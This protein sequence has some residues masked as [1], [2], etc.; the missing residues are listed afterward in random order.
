MKNMIG[1]GILLLGMAVAASAEDYNQWAAYKDITVNTTSAGAN[2]ANN[3]LGIPVLVRLTSSN[4][5]DFAVPGTKASIRFETTSKHLPYQVERWDSTGG[6]VAEVWV[7]LDTAKGNNSSPSIRMRWG[8]AG[9]VDSSNGGAVFAQSN[10]FV[11]AWHLGD[12]P[13]ITARP[14]AVTGA[15]PAT[16][17]NDAGTFGGGTYVTPTGVI[18]K[19]DVIR[20]AGTRNAPVANSDYLDIGSGATGSTQSPY[21]GNNTYAGYTDFSTGF[22]YSFW[23]NPGAAA[24]NFTYMLE[25]SNTNGGTNNIQFFRP[26]TATTYRYEHVNG[27][28]SA[29][30]KTTASGSLVQGSWQ[31]IVVTVGTGATPSV[32]IYKNGVV[33]LAASNETA[34][35]EVIART[36]AWIGKSN[37]GGDFYFN[38]SFDEP[39]I[40]NLPRSA[41]WVKL[42]YET[43][44]IGSTVLTFGAQVNSPPTNLSYSPNPAVYTVGYAIPA[45]SPSVVGAV[46]RYSVAPTL[47]AGL[48][49][50]TNT[51]VISGTPTAAVAQTDYVV[52]ATN[53]TGSDTETVRITVNAS[54]VAPTNL[55]YTALTAVYGVGAVI[56]PN[57]PTVTGTV[58][59]Y[60]VSPGLP[61]G[62]AI[63]ASTGVISGTPTAA[64]AAT[65]YTVTASNSAGSTTKA[66]SITV[67]A[68]P[69]ALNYSTVTAVYGLNAAITANTPTVTGTV[70]S[71]SVS[72]AL[73]AGLTLNTTSGVISGTPTAITAATTYTV[74]ASNLAGSTTKALSITVYGPPSGLFYTSNPVIY[75][76]GAAISQNY[77]SVT[78]TVTRFSVTPALP[79]GLVMDTLTGNISGTPTTASAAANYTVTA[80]NGAGNTTV[81]LN[82][83]I[84]TQTAILPHLQ[85]LLMIRVSDASSVSFQIPNGVNS[86]RASI[87]DMWG[88]TVWS[89][90]IQSSGVAGIHQLAWDGLSPNGNKV[91]AGLYVAR[92]K[93]TGSN[94]GS[95]KTIERKINYTP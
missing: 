39:E 12:A 52:S 35:M 93:T 20:G 71:Y 45:S 10:G 27:G 2:V 90:S 85:N 24:G 54:L 40:S 33:S 32:T 4:F 37:Y 63:S 18:G 47:P 23:V 86:V 21:D 89:R 34:P 41:D 25:L 81:T 46:T 61:A 31:H 57:N 79:A 43:Q 59:S 75:V 38:G 68:P 16:P 83:T 9:A 48:S 66:L 6:N 51:G 22:T 55:N 19:A 74:T 36:N 65:T 44:K 13:G 80:T 94:P 28:A 64:S 53:G 7:L 26:N 11:G 91:S 5:S 29:G 30:T 17:S 77:A 14:N 69:S 49:L 67:V 84:I 87:V 42:S 3:V 76:T 60:T 88:R 56:T 50:D 72:P 8:K 1:S 92:V 70:T 95:S 78:G 62:L 82:I 73:P 58:T 15:P